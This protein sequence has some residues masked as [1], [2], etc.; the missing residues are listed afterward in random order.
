MGAS[1]RR[2]GKPSAEVA[3]KSSKGDEGQRGS[4]K[5]ET[6]QAK[7]DKDRDSKSGK[8]QAKDERAETRPGKDKAKDE[9][10]RL[11]VSGSD[12]IGIAAWALIVLLVGLLAVNTVTA[13]RH[14]DSLRPVHAGQVAPDFDL[15]ALEGSRVRLSSLRGRAVLMIFW[16]IYCGVCHKELPVLEKLRKTYGASGLTVMGIHINQG[17]APASKVRETVKEMGLTMPMLLDRGYVANLYKVRQFPQM[18]LLDRSGRV[19]GV[20]VGRTSASTMAGP[21]KRVFAQHP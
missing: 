13:I 18:V 9:A 14:G 17:S 4:S 19:V 3:S 7:S 2:K 12:R 8:D 1:K 21:I 15:P 11:K 5:D 20:W 10:Q 6:P 16:S